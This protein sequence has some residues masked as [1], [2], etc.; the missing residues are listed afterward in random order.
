MNKNIDEKVV[1]DF[2]RE[3]SKF[4]QSGVAGDELQN[5][6]E[7]YFSLF[8]WE[9]LPPGAEGFDLGCGS[10]RWAFFCAPR[11]GRLHCIDPAKPA[12]EVAG[13]NLSG[14]NNCIF[15]NAGVD[16]MPLNDGSMDF[17]YSIGVLHHTPDT[18]AGI[19]TCVRKLK[20]GAPF[21]IYLYYAF[22]NRPLWFKALWRASDI[23]R[24]GISILPYPLK[25]VASQVIALLVYFPLSRFA[26]I[27]ERLGLKVSHIPLS[28]YRDKSFYTLRTDALDR[29]GTRLEKRF[30]RN[31]IEKMMIDAGLERITFR[32]QEPYWCAIGYRSA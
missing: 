14:F 29:F 4:D 13:K 30:T 8:P 18:A 24:R 10:G 1:A 28:S 3:W 12:L 25:Y 31:Q 17:G 26:G 5:I 27:A 7:Q 2:G 23:L 9:N 22:D 11:V 20:P 16:E 32:D 21:L 19:R 15:H 6:F